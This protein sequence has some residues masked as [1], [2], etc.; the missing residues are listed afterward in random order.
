LTGDFVT[1]NK[2]SGIALQDIKILMTG[3]GYLKVPKRE[4]FVTELFTLSDPVWIGDL[5]TA[6]KNLFV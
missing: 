1:K 4:I 6:P 3:L 5:R 2:V